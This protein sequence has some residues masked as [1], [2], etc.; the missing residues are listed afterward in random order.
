MTK[1]TIIL[2]AL[3]LSFVVFGASYYYFHVDSDEQVNVI[4]QNTDSRGLT[5]VVYTSGRD[6]FALDYLNAGELS[7]LTHTHQCNYKLCPFKGETTFT[8]GCGN[9][10]EGSDCWCLDSIHF[11][12]PS[13]NYD[14]C[15]SSLFS[16]MALK[17]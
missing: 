6:T 12:N 16:P 7:A 15:D 3:L 11:A 13:W 10:D 14:Q 2:A 5:S 4:K 9:C 8:H 1:I 17:Q